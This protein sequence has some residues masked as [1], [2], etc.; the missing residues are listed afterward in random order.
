MGFP[1]DYL[2]FTTWYLVKKGYVARADNAEFTLTAEGVD[3]VETQRAQLPIL[4]KMLTGGSAAPA[5]ETVRAARASSGPPI[6]LS[7]PARRSADRPPDKWK[8]SGTAPEEHGNA[9]TACVD[10]IDRRGAGRDR[11]SRGKGRRSD[12]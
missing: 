11:R 12:D 3:F 7:L 10:T 9:P 2:D 8:D 6:H 5:P 1:R 4:N